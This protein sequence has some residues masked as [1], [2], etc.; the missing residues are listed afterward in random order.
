MGLT[1]V[2]SGLAYLVVLALVARFVLSS[3]HSTRARL[4]VAGAYGITFIA[5]YLF[6]FALAGLLGQAVLGIT[7]VIVYRWEHATDSVL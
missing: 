5:G 3:E 7:L 6:H 1:V 4:L 2:Y